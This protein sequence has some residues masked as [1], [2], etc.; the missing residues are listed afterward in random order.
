MNKINTFKGVRYFE[1]QKIYFSRSQFDDDFIND[2]NSGG[3]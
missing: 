1:V 3:G 2:N